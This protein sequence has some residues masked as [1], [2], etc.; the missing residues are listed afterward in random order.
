ME[1]SE[2]GGTAQRAPAGA[3][4]EWWPV[5]PVPGHPSW[6]PPGVLPPGVPGVPPTP[7]VPV[8]PVPPAPAPAPIFTLSITV[9]QLEEL[10][11]RVV[12]EELAKVAEDMKKKFW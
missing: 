11:R 10:V 9:E 2:T 6:P 4:G 5:Y 8:T 7:T 3:E 1:G 12:R